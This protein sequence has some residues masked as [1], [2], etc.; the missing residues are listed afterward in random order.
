MF[1]DLA[2]KVRA[3]GDRAAALMES[4]I[5]LSILVTLSLTIIYM[6]SI[7]F[8]SFWQGGFTPETFLLYSYFL[9]PAMAIA[10]I[11]LADSNQIQE[12]VNLTNHDLSHPYHVHAIRSLRTGTALLKTI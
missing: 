12:P 11:Y 9:V 5:A 2:N 7:S 6:V 4:Y 3:F 10:F 1:N 8:S